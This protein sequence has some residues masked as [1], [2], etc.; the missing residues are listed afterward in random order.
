MGRKAPVSSTL[1]ESDRPIKIEQLREWLG[2]SRRYLNSEMA[3]GNL[4]RCVL[5]QNLVRLLPED[6]NEWLLSKRKG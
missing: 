5:G 4:R 3:R 1:F 6:V 2:C